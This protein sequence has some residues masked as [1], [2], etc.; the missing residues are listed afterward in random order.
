VS[1]VAINPRVSCVAAKLRVSGALMRRRLVLAAPLLT[2]GAARV[3][4]AATP[5]SRADARWWAERHAAKLR[6]L[7]AGPVELLWIGDSITQDWESSG[8]PAW[9]D[10]APV[11]QRF[12]GGRNAVNLG[13]KG[14]ATAHLL[15]RLRNGELD[16]IAPKAAVLLIGANNFGRLRWS[17]EDSLAGHDACVAEIRRRV[18]GAKLLVLAVLPSDRGAWTAQATRGMNQGLAQ[19]YAGG[20]AAGIGYVDATPLFERDG[21]IDRGQFYDPLLRPPQAAIHPTA[22]AHARLAALI[23]PQVAAMLGDRPRA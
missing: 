16:G 12:Y 5:M 13:F 23:E 10:F 3:P 17:V 11:W 18:P 6:E 14:D 7:R 21:V 15:W 19:R 20:K 4:L 2:L 22:A 8:P 1:G 9:Q